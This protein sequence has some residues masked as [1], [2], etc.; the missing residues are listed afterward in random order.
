[1]LLFSSISSPAIRFFYRIVSSKPGMP[2][3]LFALTKMFPLHKI[4]NAPA[5]LRRLYLC[6]FVFYKWLRKAVK[7]LLVVQHVPDEGGQ[8]APHTEESESQRED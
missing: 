4:K 2:V 6:V 3:D 7:H 8:Q 1:M 5:G